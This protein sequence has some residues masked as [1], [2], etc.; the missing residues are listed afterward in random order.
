MQR[1]HKGVIALRYQNKISWIMAL[2]IFLICKE[3]FPAN[4]GCGDGLCQQS[5]TKANCPGDCDELTCKEIYKTTEQRCLGKGWGKI[6]INVNGIEREILWKA[7]LIWKYGAIIA[8]HGGEGADSNFCSAIPRVHNRF[9]TE[10]LRG[11][12]VEEFGDLAIKE[13]FAVFS[14]N[15]TYNRVTDSEGRTVGKRWDSLSQEGKEN[16]DLPFIEKVIDKTIA[17]MRRSGSSNNI[18]ITGISNGGYMTILAATHFS[19]KVTAFA[20][21]SAGDPYGTYFDMS[22]KGPRKCGPGT[23]RD[24]ETNRKINISNAC[25]SDKYLDEIE[26]P[27]TKNSIPFKQFHNQGDGGCD[28]S[29]MQKIRELLVEHGYKDDGA[30]ILDP[31]TRNIE[32][33]FWQREYNQ[34]LLD[35]FKRCTGIDNKL[36]T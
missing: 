21:V 7:P 28:F 9:L 32:N 3:A 34:P 36:N 33:H 17:S 35:F 18:F 6:K 12:S 29:C 20:P 19:N 14:L 8:L 13:G 5:E 24:I 4:L 25:V 30:F 27:E 15:S 23:W 1:Y 31:G 22:V 2:S 11:V 26:W 10:T 16:I